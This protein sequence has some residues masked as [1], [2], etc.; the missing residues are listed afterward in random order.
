MDDEST[1][2][3]E[4]AEASTAEVESPTT[5]ETETPAESDSIQEQVEVEAEGAEATT[6]QPEPEMTKEQAKAFQEQRLKIKKL[7]ERLAQTSNPQPSLKQAVEPSP[8]SERNVTPEDIEVMKATLRYP[9]ID[10]ESSKFN[11]AIERRVAEKWLFAKKTG[12]AMTVEQAAKEVMSEFDKAVN[13]AVKSTTE[14]TA[15]EV[16][17]SVTLKEQSSAIAPT[18][19]SGERTTKADMDT[20]RQRTREGSNDAF[21]ERLKRIGG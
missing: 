9:E 15:K 20:L 21:M 1:E 13:K 10:P 11:P 2:V 12:L 18:K 5:T 16:K 8:T 17:E 3:V 4:T 6:Q 14:Q 19:S 7:E